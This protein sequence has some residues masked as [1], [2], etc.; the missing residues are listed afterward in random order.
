RLGTNM[1]DIS[2]HVELKCLE[3][4]RQRAIQQKLFE[5]Q[6]RVLEQ[7][8]AQE[9]LCIPYDPIGI[10]VSALTTPPRINAV[11]HGDNLIKSALSHS[12]VNAEVLSKAIGS[13]VADK[14]KSVAYAP[15]V[16]LSPELGSGHGMNGQYNRTGAKSMPVSCRT[17]TSSSHDDELVEHFR[18]MAL[19]GERPHRAA[20][21]PGAAAPSARRLLDLNIRWTSPTV[22]RPLHGTLS[23]HAVKNHP[24]GHS[25]W[26]T[27][28]GQMA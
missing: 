7:Q 18:G 16:H 22:R 26:A 23:H 6:I 19:S 27:T 8:Q 12:S 10:A 24:N 28:V 17:S 1:P 13:A 21:S 11:L 20:P 14:H 3:H 2:A 15:S 5:D 25:S 9:L 4:E